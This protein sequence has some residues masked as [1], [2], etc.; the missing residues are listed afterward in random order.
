MVS[1]ADSARYS[2]I[3]FIVPEKYPT[4]SKYPISCFE[5]HPPPVLEKSQVRTCVRKVTGHGSV[6]SI[7]RN[8][9]LQEFEAT[10]QLKELEF[11]K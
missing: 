11:F 9:I 1:E 7:E 2:S 6:S 10:I 8:T 3:P 4:R 5:K